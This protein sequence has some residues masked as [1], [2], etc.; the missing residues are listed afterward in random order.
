MFIVTLSLNLYL[1]YQGISSGEMIY[2]D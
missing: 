2:G 1:S